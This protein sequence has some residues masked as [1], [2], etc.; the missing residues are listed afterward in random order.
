M[1]FALALAA[2]GWAGAILLGP[3]IGSISS[4]AAGLLY[5]LGAFVCHQRPER[6]FHWAG[7]QLPVCARCAGLYLG[8][9]LGA[10]AWVL[11]GPSP[12]PNVSRRRQGQSPTPFVFEGLSPRLAIRM[13]AIAAAP[14]AV[15]VA[16]A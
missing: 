3:V 11:R 10:Y 15:T 2:I 8:A 12:S 14:T 6:S 9:A 4:A 7:A 1:A 5:T 13:L 16:T